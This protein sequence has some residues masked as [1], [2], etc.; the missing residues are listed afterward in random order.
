[1]EFP[2]ELDGMAA[3]Y[4]ARGGNGGNDQ[5]PLPRGAA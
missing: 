3:F 1:M 5:H 4:I 2:A